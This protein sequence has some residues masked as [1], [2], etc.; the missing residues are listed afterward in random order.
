[1][2]CADYVAPFD[3][4]I[5]RLKYGGQH[6]LARFLSHWLAWETQKAALG[7]IDLLIP[8]PTSA[9][10]LRARG[11]NQ[12]TLLAHGVGKLLDIEVH[13]GLLGK[14]RDTVAQADLNRQARQT[15][16]QGAYQCT[17]RISGSLRIALVDDV[18]TTGATLACCEEALRKAGAQSICFLA[19]CRAPE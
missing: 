17:Q 6:G 4:W 16:L 13:C 8:V 15:N 3:A 18:I 1:M 10:K 7:K 11:Y 9:A 5:T 2:V 19:V 14:N 12:A